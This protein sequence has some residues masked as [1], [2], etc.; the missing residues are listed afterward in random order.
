M[1]L[2]NQFTKQ[3]NT[4]KYAGILACV[5]A[6]LLTF[7][8]V[9]A[10]AH[11]DVRNSDVILG[12]SIEAQGFTVADAPSISAQ[13]AYVVADDGTVYFERDSHSQVQ[14]ASVTKIMTALVA[15]EY[16]D[17]QNT[18]IEVSKKAASI[19]ES[20]AS[21]KQGDILTLEAALKALMIC[22]GNDAAQAIAESMGDDILA[23]LKESGAEDL[24]TNAYDAFVYAMNKKAK[25]LGMND[26]LFHNPHGLD[27]DK[28]SGNMYS[29]AHDVAIMSQE[30]MKNETFKSIV[31]TRNDTIEVI[32]EGKKAN[33]ELESTNFMLGSYEG[34]CGIKTGYTEKAGSCFAGACERD[35]KMIYVV[36]LDSESDTQRFVDCETIYNWFY[37]RTINYALVHSDRETT[38]EQDGQMVT[39]PVVAEVSHK[40]WVNET[41]LATIPDPTATVEIF[42]LEGNVSQEITF[43]DVTSDV[44]IG[45]KVGTVSFKQH[46]EVI[47]EVDLVAAE[48]C[49]GPNFFEAIGVWWDRLFRGF[50]GDPTEATSE[51]VNT[52]PLVYGS[53]SAL[54]GSGSTL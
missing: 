16:G 42:T 30:A 17:L 48:D 31:N 25:E 46:N 23:K 9:P 50:A 35:G 39:V 22:S 32:R 11:A 14:I 49:R 26:S 13:Y 27:F 44:R 5:F 7:A 24:P 38:Y 10:K 28:Y 15:M 52:T 21:L 3:R 33:V 45:Q 54:A 2:I 53:S 41:F 6:F 12:A 20:S 8:L 18:T 40:G 51:V 34:A 29:T 47:A 4:G 37:D 43:D 36:V 1:W 19:G